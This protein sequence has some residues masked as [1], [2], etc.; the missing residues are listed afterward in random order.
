MQGTFSIDP[1]QILGTS[2]DR[3]FEQVIPVFS[4]VLISNGGSGYSRGDTI[5]IKDSRNRIVETT[6]IKSVSNTGGILTIEKLNQSVIDVGTYEITIESPVEAVLF[7]I[8]GKKLRHSQNHRCL[9]VKKS[10]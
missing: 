1:I 6:K 3:E 9:E 4:K 2:I 8:L 10:D 7:L 5:G